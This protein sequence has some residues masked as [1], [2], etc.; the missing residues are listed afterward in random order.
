MTFSGLYLPP[1]HLILGR[2]AYIWNDFKFGTH[3]IMAS[4]SL[5][6]NKQPPN[7]RSH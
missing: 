5:L 7:G 6:C 3:A 2:F 4:P 1:N